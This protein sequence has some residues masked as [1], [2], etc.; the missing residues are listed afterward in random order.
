MTACPEQRIKTPSR[1]APMDGSDVFSELA[2]L[3][4]ELRMMRDDLDRVADVLW[5]AAALLREADADRPRPQ[6]RLMPARRSNR[7]WAERRAVQK[8]EFVF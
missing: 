3:A 7:V 2:D 6:H 8:P 5:A 4:A 1:G